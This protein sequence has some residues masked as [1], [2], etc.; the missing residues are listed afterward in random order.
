MKGECIIKFSLLLLIVVDVLLTDGNVCRSE[1]D[2]Q[3]VALQVV[4]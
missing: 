2:M 1:M 4:R 3:N